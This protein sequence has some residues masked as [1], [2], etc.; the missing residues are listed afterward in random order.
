M[1]PWWASSP[2]N[3]W[4]PHFQCPPSCSA[5]MPMLSPSA[6][7]PLDLCR[8]VGHVPP[9]RRPIGRKALSTAIMPSG[10]FYGCRHDPVFQQ[11]LHVPYTIMGLKWVAA[12]P[13]QKR[14]PQTERQIFLFWPPV[15]ALLDRTGV[16][17]GRSEG[18]EGGGDLLPRREKTGHTYYVVLHCKE[19]P[20][21]FRDPIVPR[22]RGQRGKERKRRKR[23]RREKVM[24][25]PARAALSNI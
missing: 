20:F 6:H 18:E 22:V 11:L 16:T 14:E 23:R 3:R 9:T 1:H 24:K 21:L 5:R 25:K 8:Y 12:L 2:L 17:G 15:Q 10:H 19:L 7:S 13:L 4:W